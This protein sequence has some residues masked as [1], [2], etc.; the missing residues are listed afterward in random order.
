MGDYQ[1]SMGLN[2]DVQSDGHRLVVRGLVDLM[3]VDL[4]Q[5]MRFAFAAEEQ[6][7]LTQITALARM[8]CQAAPSLLKP[9]D[10]ECPFYAQIPFIE[11]SVG[12][13][14]RAGDI[15]FIDLGD[16]SVTYPAGLTVSQHNYFSILAS[17]SLIDIGKWAGNPLLSRDWFNVSVDPNGASSL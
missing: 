6:V 11:S 13:V 10:L 16:S 9:V 8:D 3:A 15:E 17:A 2:P 5:S 14:S 1:T 12:R 7:T 4:L